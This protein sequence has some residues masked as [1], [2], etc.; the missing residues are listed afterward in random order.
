M[1]V[2]PIQLDDLDALQQMARETGVGFTSLPD[3][4]EF[5]REKI[6]HSMASFLDPRGEGAQLYFFVL[7]DDQASSAERIAGCCAIEARVGLSSPFYHYR[8]GRLAHSSPELGLHRLLETLFLSS[9]HTGDAE[10][11]SLYLRPAWRGG[12]GLRSRLGTMISRV[13]WLFIAA[14]RE[15]F[16]QRV[17][18]EMRGRVDD[19]GASPFWKS[20]GSRFLPMDFGDA[21]R[22][23]GLGEKG[24][25]GELM[26]KYPIYTA[27]LTQE[28]RLSIGQ[29][30]DQTR[31]AI[32]M[33][34]HE[35]LRWEGYIDIFDGGPTMEAYI[36]D[37]RG[38]RDSRRLVA[39]V[40]PDASDREARAS[41][42]RPRW[43]VARDGAA[44]DFRAAWVSRAPR[45]ERLV[46]SLAEA[47]RL[48]VSNGDYL[49]VLEC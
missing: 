30:H 18:A 34:A 25:I 36:D 3:N 33:L 35:G 31:P 38:V 10:V 44:K 21:D 22:L 8:L 13:R 20:L 26:P 15:R 24:F 14:Q 49:R 19:Q 42:F 32:A 46:L 12:S 2:R 17:L 23:I 16:P 27:F 39:R 29:V 48:N 40:D 47:Q 4:R 5:L 28:A 37:V 45:E 6:E 11:C 7:E 41:G 43:L 9:D 1:I